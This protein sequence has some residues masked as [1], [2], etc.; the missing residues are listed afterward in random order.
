MEQGQPIWKEIEEKAS[1]YK[2][3][4]GAVLNSS[5]FNLIALTHHSTKIEGSTLSIIETQN[6][7]EKAKPTHIV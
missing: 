7:L 6:Q 1:E 2:N 5:E 4:V 3:S